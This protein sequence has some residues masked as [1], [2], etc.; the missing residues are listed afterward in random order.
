MNYPPELRSLQPRW[1]LRSG[2]EAPAAVS[3]ERWPAAWPRRS[4]R[5]SSRSTSALFGVAYDD[6]ELLGK[7]VTRGA[8]VAAR[9]ARAARRQRRGVRRRS[10][11]RCGPFLPGP[12]VAAGCSRPRWR[13]TSAA[14]RSRNCV[15]RYHPARRGPPAALRQRPRVRAGRM[16]SRAVRPVLGGLESAAQDRSPE[17]EPPSVPVSSTGTANIEATRPPPRPYRQARRLNW[18]SAPE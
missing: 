11:R 9:R 18:A 8:R 5:P 2:C 3:G 15:D 10:T 12:P 13:S 6:V 1:P 14:G 7:L 16:A 4:G 17:A